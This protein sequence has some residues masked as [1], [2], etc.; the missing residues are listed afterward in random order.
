METISAGTSRHLRRTGSRRSIGPRRPSFHWRA[1]TWR[2]VADWDL[3]TFG[4]ISR[5][6][7]EGR[8]HFN[9]PQTYTLKRGVRMGTTPT[10]TLAAETLAMNLL[11]PFVIDADGPVRRARLRALARVFAEQVLADAAGSDWRISRDAVRAWLASNAGE[12]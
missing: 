7:P 12:R 5:L 9:F 4:A 1:V 11:A 6:D 3:A 8:E 2:N 10:L